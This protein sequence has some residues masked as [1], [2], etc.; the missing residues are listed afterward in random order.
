MIL[1]HRTTAANA[2]RILRHGFRDH[3][4]YYGMTRKRRGV[5]LSNVPLDI[6]EGA[7]GDTLLRVDL[8]EQTL[9]DCE[10]L[11]EEGKPYREGVILA[12]LINEQA[13]VRIEDE[14]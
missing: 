2:K 3:I 1:Y 5:F 8:P 14:G 11:I 13:R 6:N 12:R 9:A 10:E 7:T 4:G